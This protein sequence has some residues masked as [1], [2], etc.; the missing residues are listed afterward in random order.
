M[1][2]A[3]CR[4]VSVLYFIYC[5]TAERKQNVVDSKRHLFYCFILVL[6]QLSEL[7]YVLNKQEWTARM[8]I[9]SDSMRYSPRSNELG[10][11]LGSGCRDLVFKSCSLCRE[12]HSNAHCT[13]VIH[14]YSYITSS[15]T[16]SSRW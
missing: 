8:K 16:E 3:C 9:A 5:V 10:F 12:R 6:F 1:Y 7:Q 14:R 11:G 4:N 15:D 13:S 2:S